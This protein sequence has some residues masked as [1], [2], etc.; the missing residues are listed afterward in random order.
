MAKTSLWTEI[1][2]ER[3]RQQRLR[4]QEFRAFR[5]TQERAQREQARAEKAAARKAAADLKEAKRLYLEER[6]AEAAEMS[7]A[8]QDQVTAL[9]SVLTAG[10]RTGPLITFRS[11]KR[12]ETYP[13]FDPGPLG[14]TLPAPP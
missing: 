1:Q 6:R 5:L 8:L 3:A 14:E 7:Q 12:P 11:L 4:E 2:R 10:I 13:P 9:D